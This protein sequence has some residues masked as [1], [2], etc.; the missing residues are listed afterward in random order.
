M[1]TDIGDY[2]NDQDTLEFMRDLREEI[3]DQ[4]VTIL[5]A[6]GDTNCLESFHQH[7]NQIFVFIEQTLKIEGYNDPRIVRMIIALVGDIATQFSYNNELKA[8]LT[9]QYIEQ[10]I[11]ML[12]QQPDQDSKEQAQYTLVAIKKLM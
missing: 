8:R 11:L 1:S 3:I 7:L 10:G 12:Q 4:Y 5:M 2:Q 9:Q 6:A